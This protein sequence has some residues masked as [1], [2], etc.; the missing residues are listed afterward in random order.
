MGLL[1]KQGI[2]INWQALP[3]Q[4]LK[5]QKYFIMEIPCNHTLRFKQKVN[6]KIYKNREINH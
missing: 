5:L 1:K 3:Y 6:Q 4:Q 2:N